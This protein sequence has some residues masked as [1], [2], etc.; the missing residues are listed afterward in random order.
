MIS[1]L[2]TSSAEAIKQ[3]NL[4]P[5]HPI[6][7][8]PIIHCGDHTNARL[9]RASRT[10]HSVFQLWFSSMKHRKGPACNLADQTY[11]RERPPATFLYLVFTHLP[12]SQLF[13]SNSYHKRLRRR[14]KQTQ[15]KPPTSLRYPLFS[16]H[17]Q[18]V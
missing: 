15:T 14:S 6:R 7:T 1:N 13:S 16:S 11:S 10:V 5:P 8:R 18:L 3:T 4:G 2:G 12:P 17:H 9:L